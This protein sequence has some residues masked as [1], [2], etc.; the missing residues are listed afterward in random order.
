MPGLVVDR[1]GTVAVVSIDDSG[2]RARWDELLPEIAT[3]TREIG[4]ESILL[5]SARGEAKGV[6]LVHGPETEMRPGVREHGVPFVVDLV[7]R[8]ED[9]R[10]PRSAREPAARRRARSP[11]GRQAGAQ[12]VLL[13]GRLLA[14]R[15][16]RRRD[17]GR[18]STSPR[19]RTPP[20]RR[21]SR[22]AGLDGAAARVRRRRRVRVPRRRREARADVGSGDQR[23]AEL[24]AERKVG[25]ARA[26]RVPKALIA[27][28]RDVLAKGGVFC[29]SSCSSH[30]G[31]DAFATTLDDAALARTD[32]RLAEMHGPPGDHPSLPAWPEGR[33]LKFA[34]LA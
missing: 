8:A 7:A 20:R 32:L 6:T 3:T 27:R 4:I 16:A 34:V 23:S 31:A 29:A 12:P 1:Y 25:A 21:A 11:H 28:A 19:R 10:V 9:R 13:R 33:Y 2:V 5:R 17:R 14:P 15:R 18:A 24:R 22:R 30:V 26:R